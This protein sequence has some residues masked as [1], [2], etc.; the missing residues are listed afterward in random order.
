[1]A[2]AWPLGVAARSGPAGLL[3]DTTALWVRR[4]VDLSS[5]QEDMRGSLVRRCSPIADGG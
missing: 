4:D 1:M 2:E 5:E 3:E